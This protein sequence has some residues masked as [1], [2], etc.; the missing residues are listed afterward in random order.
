M[1]GN[2]VVQYLKADSKLSTLLQ[3]TQTDSRIYPLFTTDLSKPSI[4]Y[5]DAPTSGGYVANNRIELRIITYDYDLMLEIE[6]EVLSLLDIKEHEN[7]IKI[8]NTS[9]RSF[10]NGG[11]TM[12]GP[13]NSIERLLFFN[14]IW[15]EGI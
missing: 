15:K 14:I 3:A 7:T 9:F 8:N 1:I 11:G 6:K 2:A 12:E 4:V 5:T 10:L 13:N